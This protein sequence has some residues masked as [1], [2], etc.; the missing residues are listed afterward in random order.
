MTG[1]RTRSARELWGGHFASD[2]A[3]LMERINASVGFD[4]RL[5]AEDIRGSIAHARMLAA[6]GVITEA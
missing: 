4:K 6:R 5:W 2:P 1:A 3:P